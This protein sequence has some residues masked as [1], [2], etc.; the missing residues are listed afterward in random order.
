MGNCDAADG[1]VDGLIQNPAGC[2][3]DPDSLVPQTLTQAQADAL[4]IFIR[5]VRDDR[6]RLLQPGSSVSDLSAPGAVG[7]IPWVELF[8]P[9]DPASA[10]P[11]GA[12]A[13]LAWRIA[14]STIRHVVV[15]DPDFNVNLDWPE[16]DGV[17]K[18]EAA[19]LFDRRTRLGDADQPE[20]LV[21]YL[22]RGHK[23]LLYHGY[24]DYAQTPYLTIRFYQEL[25]EMF[26]GYRNVQKR[27]R[28]FMAPGRQHCGGGPGPNS[29]DTLTALEN[30]VEHG[31]PPEGIIATKYVND[32]P[33]MGVAR[34]M[35]L[36][37]FPERASYDGLGDPR[38]AASWTCSSRDRSLLEV[39]PN[40][41][42]AGLG[43]GVHEREGRN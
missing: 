4:E 33:A 11:W 36:C 5:G 22:R 29:F 1:V 28:L 43:R 6:G 2:S 24:D 26:D 16:A 31:I 39:G 17:L 21:P 35:P 15:R 32:N 30:W 34:T 19:R 27:A 9:V 13:P 3:F 23:V 38:N 8:P 10:Q 41:I 20:K 7:F 37:K 40:G 25:A 18:S 12:A 14:D 42:Q